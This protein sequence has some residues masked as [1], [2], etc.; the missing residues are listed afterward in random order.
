ML[1]EPEIPYGTK[2]ESELEE[3][4]LRIRIR[5][6]RRTYPNIVD[7][8]GYAQKLKIKCFTKNFFFTEWRY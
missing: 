6:L 1:A 7:Y 5:P 8:K 3:L 4:D 2:N